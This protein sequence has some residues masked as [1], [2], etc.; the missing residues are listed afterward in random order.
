MELLFNYLFAIL[1]PFS[2]DG[3]KIVSLFSLFLVFKNWHS[4]KK[5]KLI[6]SIF[7]FLLYGIVLSFFSEYRSDSFEVMT[8]Y[9][10]GWFFS[11]LLGYSVIKTSNKIKLLKVY[12]CV[13]MF[14]LFIGFLAYFHIIPDQI[15]F[16]HLVE[17]KRLI[18]FDGGPELGARCNFIIIPLFVLYLFHKKSYIFLAIALYFIYAL[19]LSGTRNCYISLFITL[20]LISLFYIYKNKKF[21]KVLLI[22]LLLLFCF[23]LTYLLSSN[24]KNRI[25]KTDIK[26]DY[27]LTSRLEMYKLGLKFI[28]EKPVFGHTP[29]TAIYRQENINNLPH[30]HNIYLDI[31]VDFGFI[32][33]ILFLVIIYRIFKRLIIMYMKTKSPLPLMLIFAWIAIMISE[34]FDSFLKTPYCSGLFFWTTGLILDVDNYMENTEN[35]DK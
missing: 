15:G 22:L 8:N 20:L 7:I 10:V 5:D 14:T 2:K 17:Y 19:L 28:E 35:Y 18:V 12:L 23:S 29:K 32:G 31:L 30:F 34:C 11:F 33:F 9:S 25:N 13:F 6:L 1:Q 16:L 26:T 24:V 3:W 4:W 21:I 27:S